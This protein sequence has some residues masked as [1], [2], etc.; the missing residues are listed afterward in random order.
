MSE[1]DQSHKTQPTSRLRVVSARNHPE[2][3]WQD[4][5][6]FFQDLAEEEIALLREAYAQ[7]QQKR[8]DKAN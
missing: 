6:P 8:F 3:D 1:K 4:E 5:E 2:N 7:D